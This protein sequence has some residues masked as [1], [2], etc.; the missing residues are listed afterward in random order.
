MDLKPIK[1][2][3]AAK[4]HEH[5]HTPQGVDWK[6]EAAQ[7]DRLNALCLLFGRDTGYTVNDWGCGYG[8][9]ARMTNHSRYYGYDIV[10][11]ELDGHGT[12]TLSDKPTRIADYT[13]ASGIFNV[14]SAGDWYTYVLDSI[15][16]MEK[17]SLKGF[18]F[19]MLHNRCDKRDERLFYAS[20]AWVNAFF[21]DAWSKHRV[22]VLQHYSPYD[23][24]MM[25]H[26]C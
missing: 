10:E 26:L 4:L 20:P 5:G 3:Y 12:F 18:A 2:H 24:T 25:V 23:F 15:A 9:L 22:S 21:G 17:K 11:Q 8:R 7:M 16:T 6:D 1:S 13:V 14:K 19:N